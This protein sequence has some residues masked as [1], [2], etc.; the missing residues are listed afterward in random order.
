[1]LCATRGRLEI[2]LRAVHAFS[3]IALTVVLVIER[4]NHG[5]R[6]LSRCDPKG[7]SVQPAELEQHLHEHI[8]L[9]KAMAVSVLSV[10]PS[11]VVLRAPLAPNINLH[12][13]DFGGSTSA[14]ATLAAWSLLHTRLLD[15]GIATRLVIQRNTVEY[16][17]PIQGEFTAQSSLN[18]ADTWH[19]FARA[20]SRRGKA[21]VAVVSHLQCAGQTVGRFAGE[22][23]A[24]GAAHA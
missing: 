14:L 16:E 8:Q 13:T 20:L 15:E 24:L 3:E 5:I 7:E 22:F 17:R 11:E 6:S 18:Q 12:E 1:M 4:T 23:V 19:Q 2:A 10:E 21:R 9:S